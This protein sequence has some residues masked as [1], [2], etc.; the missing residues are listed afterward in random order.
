M[1]Q[2]QSG[3]S[4]IEVLVSL[5]IGLLLV[6]FI[7]AAYLAQSNSTRS[8]DQS[9]Q[10]QETAR[11]A[12]NLLERT[13]RQAGYVEYGQGQSPSGYCS[14]SSTTTDTSGTPLV[15]GPFIEGRSGSGHFADSDR[16]IMRTYG[17]GPAS[18]AN[19]DGSIRDCRGVSIPGQS[20]A[21][22]AVI[23][24]YVANDLSGQP[25]LFCG[26]RRPGAT[27]PEQQ[28]LIPGVESFQVLFLES[29]GTSSAPRRLLQANE[30]TD[31]RRIVAVRI[32]LVLRSESPSRSDLDSGPTPTQAYYDVFDVAYTTSSSSDAGK[33]F[34]PSSLTTELRRHLRG[35]F[36]TTIEL[37]NS[38]ATVCS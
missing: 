9:S 21:N 32:S 19:G 18:A 31:W 8:T 11:I 25:A 27:A 7:G 1:K 26:V 14:L 33:T 30:V 6:T 23:W 17:A 28:A 37:R 13:V 5:V 2:H 38:P 22:N 3:V 12:L 36:T 16:L 34:S 20:I 29:D 35:V 10:L 4:L 15:T 24:F